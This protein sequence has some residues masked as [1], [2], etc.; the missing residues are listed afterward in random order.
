M[1]FGDIALVEPGP[2]FKLFDGLAVAKCG[3]ISFCD[4]DTA[5]V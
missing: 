1:S 3:L 2:I 4:D 5:L